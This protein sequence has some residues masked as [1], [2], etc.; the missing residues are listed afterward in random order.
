VK[1]LEPPTT[2]TIADYRRVFT[3]LQKHYGL[4]KNWSARFPVF[5]R[6]GDQCSRLECPED[7]DD[8]LGQ[9]ERLTR[10]ELV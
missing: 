6:V 1:V 5:L 2:A 3:G 8:L 7:V 9:L 10:L 4:I